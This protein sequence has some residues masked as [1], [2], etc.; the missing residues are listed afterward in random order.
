MSRPRK[1]DKD[2]PM[3]VRREHGG[4]YYVRNNKWTRLGPIGSNEWAIR[5]AEITGESGLRT[6]ASVFDRYRAEV[7]PNK[8]ER[9]QKDAQAEL[10][11]LERGGFGEFM[12]EQITAVHCYQ[13][14]DKRSAKVRG[15]REISRL[16]NVLQHCI[17]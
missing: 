8:A 15:N 10:A 4:I 1:V 13:Y 11:M 12:P 14:L 3:Y 7:L 17:R 6:M 9:T 16:N 5:Y 2:L